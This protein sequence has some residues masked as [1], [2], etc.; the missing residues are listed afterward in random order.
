MPSF[1]EMHVGLVERYRL[2]LRD[3]LLEATRLGEKR[4]AR[5]FETWVK[6]PDLSSEENTDSRTQAVAWDE[7]GCQFYVQF[8]RKKRSR[9]RAEPHVLKDPHIPLLHLTEPQLLAL[10]RLRWWPE[11]PAPP[12]IVLARCA[13]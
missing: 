13:T 1:K 6:E 7:G 9:T 2:Q 12:L 5:G 3:A 8:V 10:R 4:R 11:D